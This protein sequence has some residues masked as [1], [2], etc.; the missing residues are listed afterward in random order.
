VLLALLSSA[1]R[2]FAGASGA[3][4]PPRLPVITSTIGF[5][6]DGAS[7]PAQ[8]PLT[9]TGETTGMSSIVR[10]EVSTDGGLNWAPALG[11]SPW[12]FTWIPSAAGSAHVESRAVDEDGTAETPGPGVAITIVPAPPPICPGTIWPLGTVPEITD[13]G[14]GLPIEVGVRFRSDV[15]GMIEAIR[16]YK[17]WNV[18]GPHTVNLW[19]ADGRNLGF[20]R[21]DIAPV[22]GWH[23]IR[24]EVP[25]LI[26]RDSEYVASVHMPGGHYALGPTYFFPVGVDRPPLHAPGNRIGAGNG[27]YSYGN[28]SS[29]P[30]STFNESNYW[31]D[32]RFTTQSADMVAPRITAISP[33][34]GAAAA[35]VQGEI[36]VTFSEPIDPATVTDSSF[37]LLDAIGVPVRGVV[38]YAV[39]A[40]AATLRTVSLAYGATYSVRLSAEIR[41]PAGNALEAPSRWRFTTERPSLPPGDDG[42]GGPILVIASRANP[43]TRYVP[44]ILRAEGFNA[45][46]VRELSTLQPAELSAYDVAILGEAPLDPGQVAMLSSW[47]QQGGNLIALRPDPGLASLFG[48]SGPGG[49]LANQYLRVDTESSPGAGIVGGTVQFHGVADRYD[50]TPGS[51]ARAVAWLYSSATTPSLHPAVTWRAVGSNGGE[52]SAFTYDLARSIVQTRQGNPAWSGQE[53]DGIAPRRSNDLFYGAADFDPQP[54]WIDFSKIAIPQA[55]EQQRLLANLILELTAD[56]APMP[57]FWYFPRGAKA[58]IVMTGD[59]HGSFGM[60]PRFDRCIALSDSGC[61]VDD[62]ECIRATGFLYMGPPFSDAQASF[63]QEQGFEVAIHMTAGCLNVS[64]AAL[65]KRFDEDLAAFA[66]AYPGARAPASN[67]THC[68]E[69]IDFASEAEIEAER[70][71]RYD[72]NYYYFPAEWVRNTPGL[73]TGSGLPMRFARADGSVIDCYQGATQFTDDA[74]QSIPKNLD[75]VLDHALGPE[76]WYGAFTCNVHFDMNPNHVSDA[77]I[78]SAKAHGVP[79]VSARQMLTWLDGRNASTFRDLAWS[80]GT[81]T[82]TVEQ[83]EGARNLQALLPLVAFGDTLRRLTRAG[84][85]VA[86]VAEVVK[87]VGYARFDALGGEYEASYLDHP[88]GVVPG[89][90]RLVLAPVSPNPARGVVRLAFELPFTGPAMLRIFGVRGN[91]VRT[92]LRG[93][94]REGP[95][96][97]LWDRRDNAGRSV[98]PGVYLARLDH[99]SSKMTRRIV[100]LR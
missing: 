5:P 24:F 51:G 42:P 64:R 32:V 36:R 97:V 17:V 78:A 69:W 54:D 88:I 92:L 37:V 43:F 2:A 10:V 79:V 58:V 14:A 21:L 83:A 20:A 67:R 96:A 41:D 12:T 18:T 100:L 76:G 66:A 9:I 52:A 53:R 60:E 11:T 3:D 49:T 85:Y 87:G 89:G 71:I 7:V 40:H 30:D 77:I 15:D 91:L 55:D 59:N 74:G 63:Y 1:G 35:P 72:T 6:L 19:T 45:F 80:P 57:R 4:E 22:S 46:R 48:L 47:V 94:R 86:F 44:E 65:A 75:V 38:E 62:W 13:D 70:G 82:F 90:F 25:I 27:V 29:F 98:A 56:R 16:F 33:G 50:L 8:V 73:F 84:L 68:A 95:D 23:D 34:N 93:M 39:A 99:G 61:S 81:L 26:E 28:D 31:V